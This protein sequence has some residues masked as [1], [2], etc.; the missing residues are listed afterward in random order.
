MPQLSKEGFP[1]ACVSSVIITLRYRGIGNLLEEYKGVP[2]RCQKQWSGGGCN[3]AHE[4]GFKDKDRGAYAM[5][6]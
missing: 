3:A 6:V 4:L 1:V 5:T 2:G